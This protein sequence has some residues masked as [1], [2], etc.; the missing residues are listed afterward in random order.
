[1]LG[2]WLGFGN[3]RSGGARVKYPLSPICL[4]TQTTRLRKRYSWCSLRG[5][6]EAY[7]TPH[8][9]WRSR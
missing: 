3:R 9:R 7:V 6:V 4:L 2:L 5:F 8:S 1:M